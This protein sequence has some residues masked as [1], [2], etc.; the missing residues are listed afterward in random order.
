MKVQTPTLSA[1]EAAKALGVTPATV[2]EW[3]R[4]DEIPHMRL[5]NRLKIP[6]AKL[7]ELLGLRPEELV[8]AIKS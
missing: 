4:N 1:Y 7:A 2:Y 5:G 6:T 3:C 8:E